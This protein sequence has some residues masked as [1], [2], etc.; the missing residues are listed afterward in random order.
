ME[1]IN[2]NLYLVW[3]DPGFCKGG[4]HE[5]VVAPP[6][7]PRQVEHDFKHARIYACVW[8]YI[9]LM[10]PRIVACAAYLSGESRRDL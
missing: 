5:G 8:L 2:E 7:P 1:I 4:K 6:P 9:A 10:V 3:A